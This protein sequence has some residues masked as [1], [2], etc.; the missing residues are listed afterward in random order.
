MGK[1][2]GVYATCSNVHGAFFKLSDS[3]DYCAQDDCISLKNIRLFG[4]KKELT[5]AEH[6][7]IDNGD[8]SIL[9]SIGEITG[10]LILGREIDAHDEHIYNICDDVD[11]ELEY[12]ASALCDDGEPLDMD[13]AQDIF[14]IHEFSIN[15]GFSEP[16]L[17]ARILAELPVLCLRLF[18][19]APDLLAFYP[20][21]QPY[22]IDESDK[23]RE[24]VAVELVRQ[25]LDLA[26]DDTTDSE[27]SNVIEMAAVRE[28]SED[29]ISMVMGRRR[30]GVSYPE[31]AKDEYEFE[32]YMANGFKESGNSRVLY[33]QCSNQLG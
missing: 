18:H 28:F 2:K 5:Y 6:E 33:K 14:Y 30:P 25:K 13:P 7:A 11:G 4:Y 29:E 3:R 20:S 27:P 9:E 31:S 32:F 8:Y 15:E 26:F 21:P 1:I 22:D 16:K 24:R 23:A 17:K 19:V 10:Y 12:M